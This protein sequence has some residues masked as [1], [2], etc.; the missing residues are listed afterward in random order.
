[1]RKWYHHQLELVEARV[2]WRKMNS[3]RVRVENEE[4]K[5]PIGGLSTRRSLRRSPRPPPPSPLRNPS[6]IPK[7]R[8]VKPVPP[9]SPPFQQWIQV[10]SPS[11]FNLV[12]VI[13]WWPISISSVRKI[14]LT[15][16]KA[17]NECEI[18]S[19]ICGTFFFFLGSLF[20][21]LFTKDWVFS[22]SIFLL[23]Y[24]IF[25]FLFG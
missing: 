8:P 15:N 7:K 6:P 14:K 3:G 17:V 9:P 13:I 22:Q 19:I 24:I 4:G 18:S 11:L 21:A 1:M 5:F 10:W 2:G 23:Y 20:Y 25:F 16:N 12:C